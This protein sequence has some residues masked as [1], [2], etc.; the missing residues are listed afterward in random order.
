MKTGT[1]RVRIGRTIYKIT[2]KSDMAEYPNLAKWQKQNLYLEGP[3]GASYM[4]TQR[5]D[6]SW[7]MMAV[8]RRAPHLGEMIGWMQPEFIAEEGQ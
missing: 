8:G 5:T 1:K 3:R 2:G 6:D 7:F 4:L